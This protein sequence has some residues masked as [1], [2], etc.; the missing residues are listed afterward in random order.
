MPGDPD[1][2]EAPDYFDPDEWNQADPADD[3][4]A[5]S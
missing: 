5:A 4:E 2:D 1:D 3:D